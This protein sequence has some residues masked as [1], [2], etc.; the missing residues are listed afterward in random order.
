MLVFKNELVMTC[1]NNKLNNK[2]ANNSNYFMS[3]IL[4]LINRTIDY[5]IK[6]LDKKHGLKMS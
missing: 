1:N 6:D 4:F 5:F 2:Q 3:P